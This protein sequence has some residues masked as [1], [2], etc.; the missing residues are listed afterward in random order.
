MKNFE[1]KGDFDLNSEPLLVPKIWDLAL[2]AMTKKVKFDITTL[3][4]F[5]LK[6]A[7]RM[8]FEKH[9]NVSEHLSLPIT[10]WYRPGS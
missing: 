9:L 10:L 4:N 7:K 1:N 5:L 8:S 2:E 3:V 6:I